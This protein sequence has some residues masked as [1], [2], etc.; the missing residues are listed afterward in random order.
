MPSATPSENAPPPAKASRGLLALLFAEAAPL[1]LRILGRTLMHAAIVGAAAGVLGATFLTALDL[2]ERVVLG[3]LAG[4]VPLRASGEYALELT[5]VTFRP[6][7]LLFIPAAGGLVSGL[8]TTRFAPE[9]QG[10]G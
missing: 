2:V 10:G 5:N 3:E 1:D 9:A 4:Y 8:L 6:W 7:L